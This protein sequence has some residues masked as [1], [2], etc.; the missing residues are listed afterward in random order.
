MHYCPSVLDSAKSSLR[1]TQQS[2]IKIYK[3]RVVRQGDGNVKNIYSFYKMND[4]QQ[5]PMLSV[6]AVNPASYP[7][8]KTAKLPAQ[9]VPYSKE[10]I[11]K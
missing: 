8:P 4:H 6:T 9:T 10:I 7:R 1:N 2:E 11:L 3:C 5:Q